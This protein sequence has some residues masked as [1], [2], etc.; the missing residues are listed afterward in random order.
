[1]PDPRISSLKEVAPE[2][3]WDKPHFKGD[4]HEAL[5]TVAKRW[6]STRVLLMFAFDWFKVSA[7]NA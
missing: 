2:C 6:G 3:D 5:E 4:C 7:D 1:M